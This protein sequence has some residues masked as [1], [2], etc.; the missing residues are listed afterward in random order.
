MILFSLVISP[1]IPTAA[2]AECKRGQAGV[3]PVVMDRNR[4]MAEGRLDGKPI[5]LLIDT[6][7]SSTMALRWTVEQRGYKPVY[8]EHVKVIGIG[9]EEP[10]Y[11]ITFKDLK[12]GSWDLSDTRWMVA[13][14]RRPSNDNLLAIVGYDQLERFDVEYDLP[15]NKIIFWRHEGCEEHLL[16]YWDPNALLAQFRTRRNQMLT[17]VIINGVELDAMVDTGAEV[18]VLTREGAFKL[19]LVK[20]EDGMV[21]AGEFVGLGPNS[22]ESYLTVLDS[23][24]IGDLTVRNAKMRVADLNRHARF[25]TTGSRLDVKRVPFGDMTLGADFFRAHRVLVSQKQGLIY[26]THQGGQI[27]QTE[28]PLL[29]EQYEEAGSVEGSTPEQPKP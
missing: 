18:S 24:T 8:V 25:S 2:Q 9:G 3:L 10:A 19:G 23:V 17:T 13:G 21:G 26:F 7:A 11:S 15:N 16:S 28:G 4:V 29:A 14:Q 5:Y 27:F 12:I 6:G 1:W 22:I 20:G